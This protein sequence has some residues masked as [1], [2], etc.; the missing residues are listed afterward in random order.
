MRMTYKVI[1]RLKLVSDMKCRCCNKDFTEKEAEEERIKNGLSG[2]IFSRY[3]L[4]TGKIEETIKCH[5]CV[6]NELPP[7]QRWFLGLK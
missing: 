5:Q 2:F 3:N 4:L 7:L 6:L 1:W